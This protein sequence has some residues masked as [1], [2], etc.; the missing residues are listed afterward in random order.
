MYDPASA[1]PARLALVI[2]VHNDQPHL[3]RL[4]N[5]AARLDLF[6][7]IIICDDGSDLPVTLPEALGGD[8]IGP[9]R[10][11]V[12]LVRHDTPR[13]AGAARNTALA[14]VSASH[15]LYFDSDDLLTAELPLIWQDLQE[16]TFDFCLF[17]H[18]DSQRDYFGGWGQ[19]PHDEALWRR[20]GVSQSVMADVRRD[21]LWMLAETSN[22]PWN[23]IYRT[24]FL[25]AQGLR[26]TET[27]V[28]NDIELH[29]GSFL[30]ASRVLVSSRIGALHVVHPGASR[31]TNRAGEER[32]RVFE[33]LRPVLDR[34]GSCADDAATLAFLRFTSGLAIWI[35]RV[36][37]PALVPEFRHR[38][39]SFL[40]E[41]LPPGLFARLSREDPVLA[42]RLCLQMGQQ[43]DLT[44]E[45]V[46]C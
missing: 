36:I 29:W 23:K 44:G 37:A 9:R 32:L 35:E 24:G 5:R 28:H 20:A 34:L 40:Q 19:I 8:L 12:T 18:H 39:R 21:A 25:R 31:L 10:C 1:A 7:Q 26:C 14:H 2:P 11:P 38:L 17:R 6:D 46:A 13:G 30:T 41:A 22:Y 3:T 33:A 4:L 15:L 27:M 45:T 43:T 16:Q 42:L